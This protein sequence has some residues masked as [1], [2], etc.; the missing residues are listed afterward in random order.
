MNAL[1][2]LIDA[3]LGLIFWIIVLSAIMSWLIALNIVNPRNQFVG[4]VWDTLVRLSEPMLNPLRRV[5]PNLGG[6]DISP[7][8]VLLLISFLRNLLWWDIRPALM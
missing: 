4:M 1:F 6:I 5:L 2:I 7:I 8:I 3:V